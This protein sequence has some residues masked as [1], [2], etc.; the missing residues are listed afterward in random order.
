MPYCI[1]NKGK[2]RGYGAV[3][4]G[5]SNKSAEATAVSTEAAMTRA[6]SVKNAPTWKIDGNTTNKKVSLKMLERK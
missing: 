3:K 2:K 1:D 5:T 4:P 6:T